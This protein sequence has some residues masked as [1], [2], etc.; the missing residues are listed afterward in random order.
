MESTIPFCLEAN[1]GSVRRTGGVQELID[2]H[3]ER[4]DL[5]TEEWSKQV[6]A[7]EA[8]RAVAAPDRQGV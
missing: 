1:A 7:D 8:Q 3:D 4:L 2:R 6:I 5:P